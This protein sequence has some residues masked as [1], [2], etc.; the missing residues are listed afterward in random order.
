MFAMFCAVEAMFE[1]DTDGSFQRMIDTV[2]EETSRHLLDVLHNKYHF[3][4]HLRVR[5]LS[6]LI[7]VYW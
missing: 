6:W 7:I 1:Q 4:D 2:Y 5:D 3:M